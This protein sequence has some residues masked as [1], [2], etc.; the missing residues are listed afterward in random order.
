[1]QSPSL[2]SALIKSLLSQ[3]LQIFAPCALNIASPGKVS[4]NKFNCAS[5][6]SLLLKILSQNSL[7]ALGTSKMEV[8]FSFLD[9]LCLARIANVRQKVAGVTT[10]EVMVLFKDS[11]TTVPESNFFFNFF[12]TLFVTYLPFK[13]LD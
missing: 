7:W 13:A 3:T 11:G 4:G 5:E 12:S 2:L 6:T 1:M 10:T 9:C 8:T